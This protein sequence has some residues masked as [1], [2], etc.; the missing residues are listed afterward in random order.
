[1]QEIQPKISELNEKHKGDKEKIALET[2]A[3]YKEHKVNPFGS[4]LPMLIQLPILIA[5]FYVIQSGLDA[6]HK[7]LLYP[8]LSGANLNLIN[9]NFLGIL[10]LTKA[11]VYVLPIIVGGLQYLQMRMSL[12]RNKKKQTEKKKSEMDIANKTMTYTMPLMIAVFTASAPAG[13]GIYWAFSTLYGIAQ[14]YV[15]NKSFKQKETTIRVMDAGK[16]QAKK[17]HYKKL[18]D[19]RKSSSAKENNDSSTS[20]ES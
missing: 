12:S 2:M 3:I 19:E 14:Q 8:F 6:S 9:T 16:N 7:Y 5:L 17:E 10:E 1:M 11:N 20:I 18:N 4:C 15:V 13:V